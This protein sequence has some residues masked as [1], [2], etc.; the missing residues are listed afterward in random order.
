MRTGTNL[1]PGSMAGFVTLP[2]I[3]RHNSIKLIAHYEHPVHVGRPTWNMDTAMLGRIRTVVA[4][5]EL[6]SFPWSP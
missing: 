4:Q 1:S 3:S 2:R 6:E 5:N